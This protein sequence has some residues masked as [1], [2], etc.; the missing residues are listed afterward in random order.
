MLNIKD[1]EFE[2]KIG[3]YERGLS[4]A[5]ELARKIV[6]GDDE[7]SY[8]AKDLYNI[9]GCGWYSILKKFTIE[10]VFKHIKKYKKGQTKIVHVGD[11]I[12][13]KITD[14]KA[15]V[16]RIDAWERYECFTDEGAQFILDP[17]TFKDYWI[18]TGRN[19]PQIAEV[20]KQMKNKEN[21]NDN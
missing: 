20:L 19:F 3:D 15:V 9:F 6:I 13:S 7:S 11:E 17:E 5:W 8:S 4:D 1:K 16:Q 14:S 10:E 18:K 12:Y 21:N 2:E